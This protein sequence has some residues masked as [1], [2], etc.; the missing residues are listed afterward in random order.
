MAV[1]AHMRWLSGEEQIVTTAGVPPALPATVKA[2][3]N[4]GSADNVN[5]RVSWREVDPSEYAQPGT[6]VVTGTVE[7]TSLQARATVTVK[8]ESS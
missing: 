1:S 7:G 5:T 4:D 8:E 3:F 2:T 6:F